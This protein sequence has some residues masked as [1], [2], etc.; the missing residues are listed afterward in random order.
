MLGPSHALSGAA[1]WA[2][3]S[4][5]MAH[6]AG[7]HQTPLQLAVGT[8]MC[9]GGALMPDL[10]LSGRVTSNQGGATVAHTFGVFS[11]FLAEVIEK[12]SL[13]VY[14]VTKTRNDPHRDNGHRTLTHTLIFNVAVGAGVTALCAQF[15][16]T[17]VI[18]VLF[19]TFAMAL[20]GLF[21][22]WAQRAGWLI[23]TLVSAACAFFVYERLPGGRGYPVLGLAIGIGGIVHL[24]GDMLTRHGC[25][26]LWPLPLGRRMWRCVGVPDPISVKVG[27]KVEKYVLRTAFA[28]AT[29]AA[30]GYLEV[31]G[32]LPASA[33]AWLVFATTSHK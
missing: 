8:A 30:V 2:G 26:L 20:R 7:F 12:V 18:A 10:D 24:L 11:L 27:G 1:V 31:P 6:F 21:Q 22:K 28:L 19:F 15:G 29:I 32:R 23:V 17:A 16:K 5:A 3:G 14:D 9:A 25:P 13:G 33:H 4:L